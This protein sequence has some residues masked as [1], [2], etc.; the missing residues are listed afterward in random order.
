MTFQKMLS[1]QGLSALI[2]TA[3]A[4][5]GSAGSVIPGVG[6]FQKVD[7]H[8]YRGA[9]PTAEGFANLKKLGIKIVIDLREPGDRSAAE[10]KVVSAAGMQYVSVPMYGM[11]TPKNQSV[12]KAL[13][14]MEDASVGPVFVHCKRGADRTG[15]VIACYR[16][17]HD[18]WKNERA[19]A[20]A[21][22]MGMSWFQK[23]IQSYVMKYQ[24]RNLDT[25]AAK[26]FDASTSA[27]PAI[28]AIPAP[29]Q[30]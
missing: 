26:T 8:V 2:V 11:E 19:L 13:A 28:A 3:F 9:Q 18:R 24:P 25:L 14:L 23:A 30:P 21:K 7:D 12:Q 6:N 4:S 22:S 15:G 29:A 27:P 20:E 17:E 5:V 10:D 16:V 1:R